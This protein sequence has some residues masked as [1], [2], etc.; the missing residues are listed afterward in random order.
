MM[1]TAYGVRVGKVG[2]YELCVIF[3]IFTL[4]HFILNFVLVCTILTHSTH[5]SIICS[6]RMFTGVVDCVCVP[7]PTSHYVETLAFNCWG[8]AKWL[9]HEGGVLINRTNTNKRRS[10]TAMCTLSGMWGHIKQI[11]MSQ[12]G[13]SHQTQN[14]NP[15]ILG[16]P[17]SGMVRSMFLCFVR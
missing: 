8:F 6:Q 14:V 4:C 5:C 2:V 12:E 11:S 1:V 16:F 15:L 10:E 3:N 13:G 7:H 17:T 9:G